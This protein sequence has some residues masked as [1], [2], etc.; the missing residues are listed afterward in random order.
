MVVW[1]RGDDQSGGRR[2]PGRPATRRACAVLVGACSLSGLAALPAAAQVSPPPPPPAVTAPVTTPA[3]T[4]PLGANETL[5]V[6][7]VAEVSAAKSALTAAQRAES[8]SRQK[9]AALDKSLADLEGQR[10][11]LAGEERD[12]ADRLEGTRSHLRSAAVS[13]Y[14]SGG[15]TTIGNQLLHSKDLE[16]FTRNRVYGGAVLDSQQRTLSTYRVELTKVTGVT[17][18]LGRQIDRVKA[19]RG[20]VTQEL[21]ALTAERVLREQDL[22]QKQ[23]LNQLVTAAAPVLPSDIPALVLDAYVRGAAAAN[24]RIPGCRIHWTALAAIGRT[25]SDHAREG[26]GSLTLAGDVSPRILGPR[27]DGNGF[28]FVADTDG[29]ALDGDPV[30]DRAVGPMQF[31]P[32]TWRGDGEDGNGDGIRDPNNIYDATT[33]A[34][35]Y[36]CRARQGLDLDQNLY[37]AALSYNHSASYAALIVTRAREYINLNLAGLPPGPPPSPAPVPPPAPAPPPAP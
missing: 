13:Q 33:A 3:L 16:A 32:G 20:L 37:T 25:E 19:D 8:Q 11:A 18:N 34:G 5:R 26:N 2:R 35:M 24:R 22:A 29:G 9:A 28:A 17:S 10:G 27:L 7:T 30:V 36:L 23:V 12:A 21:Q 6:R 14:I 31:I 4:T 1:G 15:G